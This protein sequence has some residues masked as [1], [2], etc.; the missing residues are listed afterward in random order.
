[1]LTAWNRATCNGE[2]NEAAQPLT[3][4]FNQVLS[5]ESYANSITQLSLPVCTL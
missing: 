2:R 5:A 3:H 1:M 4:T